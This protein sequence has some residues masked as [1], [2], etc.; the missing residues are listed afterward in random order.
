MVAAL[1]GKEEVRICVR[2]DVHAE[3]VQGLL[4][5]RGLDDESRLFEVPTNDAWI[6]DHGPIFLVDPAGERVAADFGFDSWGKKYPPW[7]LD[8]RVPEQIADT[9][10]LPRLAA[11]FVLEGGS[12]DG[13]GQGIVLTTSACLL[14]PNRQR[15]GEAPRTR[16]SM[17]AS[18]SAWLSADQVIWLEDGIEG[19]DTDGHIDDIARFVDVSTVVAVREQDPADPNHGVLESNWETLSQARDRRG[20]PLRPVALPMPPPVA[21]AGQRLPASYA[22]FYLANG[23]ALVPTFDVP[24][25]RWALDLL[26]ELLPGRE[27]VPIPARALV[28]GLGACH[29]L[30]QQEPAARP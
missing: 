25:D 16:E 10:R 14:N 19:D 20:N 4:K 24:T 28:L 18:L 13:N 3:R 27:V 15:Q 29:C 11:E 5:P 6:R 30:T 21:Q 9:L 17:E 12:V 23:I 22:N 26:A 2:D 1:H 7:E 8:E